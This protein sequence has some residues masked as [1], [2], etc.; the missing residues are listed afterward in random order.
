M[1]FMILGVYVFK[2]VT[3]ND[4]RAVGV[5]TLVSVRLSEDCFVR[6]LVQ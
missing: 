4:K 2:D 6:T 5:A 3:G 1:K